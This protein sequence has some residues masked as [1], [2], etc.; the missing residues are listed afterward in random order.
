[1]PAVAALAAFLAIAPS[2]HAVPDFARTALN[3]IPSGQ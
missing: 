3:I 1:L 2:G